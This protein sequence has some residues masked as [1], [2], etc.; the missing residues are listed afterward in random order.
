MTMMTTMPSKLY[1]FF[2]CVTTLTDIL[3]VFFLS[4]F[5]RWDAVIDIIELIE[6]ENIL[7]PSQVFSI[8][9]MNP[10]LPLRVV[11][12]YVNNVFHVR[13][14]RLVSI[15]FTFLQTFLAGFERPV[16]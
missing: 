3:S 15:L 12:N 16:V 6:K 5:F 1:S 8:L 9:S 11:S 10:D 14:I 13:E 2:D 4:V 7:S